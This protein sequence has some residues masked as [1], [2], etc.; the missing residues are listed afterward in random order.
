[1][2]ISPQIGLCIRQCP[3]TFWT[4]QENVFNAMRLAHVHCRGQIGARELSGGN[5]SRR[6]VSKMEEFDDY[7]AVECGQDISNERNVYCYTADGPRFSQESIYRRSQNGAR[8]GVGKRSRVEERAKDWP[9]STTTT[10]P[11]WRIVTT[12]KPCVGRRNIDKFGREEGSDSAKDG[13][14]Q[15]FKY[16]AEPQ[17]N[18]SFE[19]VADVRHSVISQA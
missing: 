1:M 6:R 17:N 4:F 8:G 14:F 12:T 5:R 10:K 15:L 19:N 3:R 11:S 18:C 2:K 9:W 13:L 16:C 7:Q